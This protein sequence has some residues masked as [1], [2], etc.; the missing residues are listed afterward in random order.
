MRHLRARRRQQR[1]HSVYGRRAAQSRVWATDYHEILLVLQTT[2]SLRRSRTRMVHYLRHVL[3]RRAFPVC[4]CPPRGACCKA[5]PSAR[6][7]P[8]R[9]LRASHQCRSVRSARGTRPPGV[10][11]GA[12]A[13][14]LGRS[15]FL[16]RVLRAAWR[17]LFSVRRLIQRTQEMTPHVPTQRQLL[18]ARLKVPLKMLRR[19]LSQGLSATHC[20]GPRDNRARDGG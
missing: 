1:A 11:L 18:H 7:V 19:A 3:A 5:R 10:G 20:S 4:R 14:V 8:R 2:R 17:R 12:V 6:C 9:S 15:V 13:A 16:Q